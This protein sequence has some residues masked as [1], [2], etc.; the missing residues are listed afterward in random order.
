MTK[1]LNKWLIGAI[2][3]IVLAGIAVYAWQSY[4]IKKRD[5]NIFH[6]NGRIE[7]T[8]IN[9]APKYDERVKDILVHEGDYVKDGEIVAIMD[10]DVL[11]AKLREAKAD[12]LKAQSSVDITLSQLNQR[13]S[14]KKADEALVRQREAELI[15]ADKRLSRSSTLV[16]EGATSQQE[17]DDDIARYHSAIATKEAAIAQVAAA[18]AAIIA[19]RNKVAGAE[20][21]V[22]AAEATVDRIQT[23][24][25]DSALKSPRDGRVQY[26][27]AEPGEV[28]KAGAKVLSI[29]DLSD[30]YMTF[31]LP[32]NLVGRIAIGEEVRLV[33][34]PLPDHVIPAHVTYISDVAQF[35]PKTVE[36]AT[37]REKLMFRVKAHIPADLLKK[38]LPMV[39]TGVPGLA[40][41]RIDT[42]KPW[43]DYLQVKE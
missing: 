36:T 38:H 14:E 9:I 17:V 13:I 32:T 37:E 43:P 22:K 40:Y 29:V 41:I 5:E 10:T 4:K 42:N 25:N 39:K 7:A 30:V 2:V 11:N 34:D 12:L 27:I 24:I 6:S 1:P 8:E 28:L 20:Y 23:N 26:R 18:D 3:A 33:L 21:A 19:V 35:T 16:K 15:V 31:F